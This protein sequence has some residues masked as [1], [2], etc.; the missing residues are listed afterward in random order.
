MLVDV[1]STCVEFQVDQGGVF[2][3]EVCLKPC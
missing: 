3:V 1:S 2:V